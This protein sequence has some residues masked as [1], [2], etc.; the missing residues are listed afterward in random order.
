M[1]TAVLEVMQRQKQNEPVIHCCL[2]FLLL[3][4]GTGGGGK[5]RSVIEDGIRKARTETEMLPVL[6]EVEACYKEN[7][8]VF[9]IVS[10]IKV[11]L[12]SETMWP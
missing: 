5:G 10:T 2:S 4:L 8:S 1:F 11:R 7:L 12:Q 6:G 3:L 9:G